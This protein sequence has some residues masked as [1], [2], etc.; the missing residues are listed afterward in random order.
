MKITNDIV[1]FWNGPFSNWYPSTFIW[2]GLQFNCGE[3]YMMYRKADMFNDDIS[4]LKILESNDPKEQKALG[5]LVKNFDAKAWLAVCVPIMVDGLYC[6]F[7]QNLELKHTLLETGNKIIAEA[8]PVDKIWGIGLAKEDPLALDTS[9]W[10]GENLLGITLMKVREK[11]QY[12]MMNEARTKL[13]EKAAD[14]LTTIVNRIQRKQEDYV[15]IYPV[16]PRGPNQIFYIET[17]IKPK[18][19]K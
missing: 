11:I 4:A 13:L 19:Q 17:D 18:G 14:D 2:D 12:N 10:K 3:Q 7:D 5:R 15:V 9:T 6:K 8:S 1:L 16:P